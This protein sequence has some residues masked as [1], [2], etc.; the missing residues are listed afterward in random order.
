MKK[1]IECCQI[2]IFQM[3]CYW[4]K[5]MLFGLR[6]EFKLNYWSSMNVSMNGLHIKVLELQ[7]RQRILV[8]PRRVRQTNVRPDKCTSPNLHFRNIFRRRIKMINIVILNTSK[9]LNIQKFW[10]SISSAVL[11]E[12]EEKILIEYFI[13]ILP[14]LHL[15]ILI[16][17]K[18][19]KVTNLVILNFFLN[20]K[21]DFPGRAVWKRHNSFR[22]N[23]DKPVFTSNILHDDITRWRYWKF[24]L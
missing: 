4:R 16:Y 7:P 10:Q 11:M 1:G 15:R 13:K 8:A 12:P 3:I 23:E 21:I 9:I 20:S 14:L 5:T 2:D 17:I 22:K 24:L 19:N 18:L 6:N